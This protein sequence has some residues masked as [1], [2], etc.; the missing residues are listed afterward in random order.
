MNKIENKI[1]KAKQ[2]LLSVINAEKGSGFLL[3]TG[4][5]SS[6]RDEMD[7]TTI[8][9]STAE[10]TTNMIYNVMMESEQLSQ[11]FL[12]AFIA[13]LNEM[14]ENNNGFMDDIIELIQSSKVN[15]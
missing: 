1:E 9:E 15:N 2:E 5:P 7:F 14:D 12:F 4:Y 6:N 8:S 10:I 3:L 11:V 13:Y